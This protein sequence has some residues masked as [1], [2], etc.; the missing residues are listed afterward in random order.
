[1]TRENAS[2][3]QE[4]ESDHSMH[5]DDRGIQDST[6]AQPPSDAQQSGQDQAARPFR[7]RLLTKPSQREI[8][9]TRTN[10][11]RGYTAFVGAALFAYVT[12]VSPNGGNAVVCLLAISL[13]A[14]VGHI[15]IDLA[16]EGQE[17]KNSVVRGL[18]V[19]LGVGPSLLAFVLALW[20]VSWL[21]G[22]LFAVGIIAWP[23]ALLV[24]R[25]LG[26]YEDFDEV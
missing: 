14:L 3:E 22:L 24:V 11:I 15:L 2:G 19:L 8:Y 13:P 18:A 12:K 23:L 20:S 4:G 6:Q 16:V 5:Q 21:A 26:I 1:M 17:R 25:E 7:R 10:L 9:E